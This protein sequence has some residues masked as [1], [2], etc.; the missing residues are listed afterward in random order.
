MSLFLN[1]ILSIFLNVSA[2]E[3]S[4]ILLVVCFFFYRLCCTLSLPALWKNKLLGNYRLS[5]IYLEASNLRDC[6]TYVIVSALQHKDIFCVDLKFKSELGS[7]DIKCLFHDQKHMW[8][9]VLK[10]KAFL[11]FENLGWIDETKFGKVNSTSAMK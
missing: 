6:T 4:F 10:S 3:H 2:A 8:C 9:T 11:L 5:N 1:L 7:Y